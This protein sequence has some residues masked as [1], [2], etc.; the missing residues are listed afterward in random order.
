ME[1]LGLQHVICHSDAH[2]NP[3]NGILSGKQLIIA[4][5]LNFQ[6]AAIFTSKETCL[7][8]ALKFSQVWPE[9]VRLDEA[10]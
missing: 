7:R 1:N 5:I 9:M 10:G 8:K 3:L 4:E 6:F 2:L